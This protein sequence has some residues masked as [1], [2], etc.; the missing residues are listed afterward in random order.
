MQ[1]T[2]V[3]ILMP[4][5]ATLSLMTALPRLIRKFQTEPAVVSVGPAILLYC[6]MVL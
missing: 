6:V 3:P 4:Q 1:T 2:T 5:E